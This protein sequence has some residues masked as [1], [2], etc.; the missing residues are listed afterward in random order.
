MAVKAFFQWLAGQSGYRRISYSDAE[1][2]NPSANDSRIA[3]ARRDR[4]VPTMEQIRQVIFSIGTE[5]DVGR[6]DQAL[7]AF[8][9][10]SGARD[11]AIAS[12]ALRH[13]DLGQRT[14]FQDARTVRRKNRKT[15]ISWFFPVGDDIDQIVGDWIAYLKSQGFG[16]D[17]PLFPAT[18]IELNAERQ[19]AAAGLDRR[20][21]KN[22]DPIRRIFRERFEAAGLPYF[23][24]HLLRKTLSQLGEQLCHTPEEFKAW[25][26]NLG[27]E[28][29]L[30]TFRAY[31]EVPQRRQGE[32][33]AGL[34]RSDNAAPGIGAPDA[35]T[36][37]AVLSHL[38]A[39]H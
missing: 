6:R 34:R 29:V 18:R 11:D 21:W 32:I 17:D 37:R 4:P 10:L 13:V 28:H 5:T 9:P 25:S 2:F 8:A 23:H 7:I 35:E 12:L 39:A 26:Q 27:H 22:A 30:T 20:F 31:G 36:I 24:P 14:V 1:Y 19:F 16:P 38:A 15:F 3:T 33:I